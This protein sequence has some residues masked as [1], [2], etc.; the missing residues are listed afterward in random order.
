MTCAGFTNFDR[1]ADIW[2]FQMLPEFGFAL[3]LD[4]AHI[5][6]AVG[7]GG[8]GQG[9]GHVGRRGSGEEA[10]PNAEVDVEW[11]YVH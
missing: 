5:K 9:T 11:E 2:M 7:V 4:W 1:A 3:L 10:N 8:L 6:T